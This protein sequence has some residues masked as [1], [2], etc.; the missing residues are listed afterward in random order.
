MKRAKILIAGVGCLLVAVLVWVVMRSTRTSMIV[1]IGIVATNT[2][3]QVLF[4]I[5]MVPGAIAI[6]IWLYQQISAVRKSS[7]EDRLKKISTSY[8]A[9]ESGQKEVRDQLTT[10]KE[11]WPKLSGKIDECL[12]QLDGINSQYDRFDHLIASNDAQAV[13][14]G[15]AAFEEIEKTLVSNLKWVINIG[16]A[17]D[18][19]DSLATDT[20]C[21]E[22]I[23]RAIR[24]N[25]RV[26]EK[27]N[28]FLNA[29]VDNI[30]KGATSKTFEVDAWLKTISDQ[31][32][33]S[34]IGMGDEQT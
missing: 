20:Q 12:K 2:L 11:I 6:A 23:E 8:R 24:E 5:F 33:Q 4:W 19:S 9:K 27:G 16:I 25:S 26:L 28:E 21:I 17:A 1:D 18:S 30:S 13:L 10:M 3:S 29:L 15:R 32:Q 34:L 7:S 22:K 31:N 14:G